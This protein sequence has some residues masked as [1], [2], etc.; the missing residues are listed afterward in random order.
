MD[1]GLVPDRGAPESRN[2]SK[3][4]YYHANGEH[5][6]FFPGNF[7]AAFSGILSNSPDFNT[8]YQMAPT[9]SKALVQN[10]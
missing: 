1:P 9:S 5:Q 2:G 4:Q 10:A 7:A 6:V 3:R 8:I